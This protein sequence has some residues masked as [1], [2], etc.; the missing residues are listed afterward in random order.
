[1]AAANNLVLVPGLLCTKALWAPQM[2]VLGDAANMT[3]ADH[4]RH[5]SMEAIARSILADAPERFALAGL[6]MGGYIACEI[7]R[8]APHRVTKLAL[9]D[10]GARADAPER[11]E[12]RLSLI[13]LAEREGTMKAQ[14]ALLPVLIH[15]AR[16]TDRA[17][18]DTVLQMGADTG[19]AAFKRQQ[20]ALMQRSDN[21]PLLP[22]IKCPTLVIVGR[23]DA[24]TPPALAEE[25]AAG[26]PGARLEMIPDCGHLSTLE[27]PDAV[28]RVMRVWLTAQ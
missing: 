7:V 18:V 16:L 25:I 12:Q 5:E 3:V 15:K 1:M 19:T 24:L 20:T 2:A 10:T 23:E 26:I 4:T 9:L 8:Q 27:R 17:L 6:S 22:S 11:R 28:N 21:R 13:A 14:E